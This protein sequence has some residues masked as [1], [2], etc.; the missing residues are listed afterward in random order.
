MRDC[1]PNAIHRLPNGEVFIADTCIGC[2]NC[3][4]NCPYGVIQLAEVAPKAN[5][6]DRLRGRCKEEPAKTAV[7]CDVCTSLKGGPA[8]VRACPTGAAIRIHAE[9]VLQLAKHRAAARQ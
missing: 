8:C 7:K 4:E 3:V 2:G 9:D 6:L 5:L 1:P